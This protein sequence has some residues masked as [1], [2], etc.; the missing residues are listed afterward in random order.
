MRATT[1]L[2]SAVLLAALGAMAYG[3][4]GLTETGTCAS[5]GPYVSARE[6]PDGTGTTVLLVSAGAVVYTIG[7]I[8]AAYRS[9][10]TG[11]FWFGALFTALGA[12]FLYAQMSG[13]VA[14]GSG[15]VGWFLGGLFLAMGLVPLIGGAIA[16]LRERNDDD[17]PAPFTGPY[18]VGAELLRRQQ[19]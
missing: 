6:C 8:I 13:R 7:V 11:T 16:M 3:I 12:T 10:A 4:V 9:F 14:E 15:G 18:I 5:G 1:L 17:E 19:P 2:L